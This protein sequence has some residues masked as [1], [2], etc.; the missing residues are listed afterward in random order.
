MGRK[1]PII[2]ICD[3]FFKKTLKIKNTSTVKWNLDGSQAVTLIP[4]K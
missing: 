4:E 3:V 1:I 2:L